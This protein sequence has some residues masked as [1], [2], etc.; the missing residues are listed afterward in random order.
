M[1]YQQ[2]GLIEYCT[3]KISLNIVFI[4]N[5]LLFDRAIETLFQ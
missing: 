2:H 3:L 4:T 5:Q 1:L